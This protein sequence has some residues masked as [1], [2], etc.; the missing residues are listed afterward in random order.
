MSSMR[1]RSMTE[2]FEST[3]VVLRRETAF[4]F[5]EGCDRC[6]TRSDVPN[7]LMRLTLEEL[8]VSGQF[9]ITRIERG[10]LILCT[11]VAHVNR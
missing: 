11:A 3:R 6:G 8:L 5:C 2:S 1:R 9:H 4:R 7:D 10:T